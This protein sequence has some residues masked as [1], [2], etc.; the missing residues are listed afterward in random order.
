MVRYEEQGRNS[1][2]DLLDV[3]I[4]SPTGIKVP[5]RDLVEVSTQKSP[6][7]V[8]RENM[9]YTLD[10][11]GFTQGRAF[12]HVINDIKT[13]ID[14]TPLPNGYKVAITGEQADLQDSVGDLRLLII[15][16]VLYS[17]LEDVT[18]KMKLLFSGPKRSHDI[19]HDIEHA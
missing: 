16:P 15:V 9:E 4:V 10:I 7:L 18:V 13:L 5:L 12:S 3:A 17:S 8:T 1:L 14:E 2:E 19:D 6:N 11:Y